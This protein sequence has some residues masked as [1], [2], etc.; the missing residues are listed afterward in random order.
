MGPS[1]SQ[2]R[3]LLL[4]PKVSFESHVDIVVTF[5][6]NWKILNW[7]K[8]YKTRT[9]RRGHASV[10]VSR[11]WRLTNE[12]IIIFLYKQGK[13]KIERSEVMAKS[14][15]WVPFINLLQEWVCF[16]II[17]QGGTKRLP[18]GRVP[19]E[20]DTWRDVKSWQGTMGQG[21]KWW[22]VRHDH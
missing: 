2:V 14:P 3:Q 16:I 19:Q 21:W 10:T 7:K 1:S 13:L 20:D 8:N 9:T 18:Q 17:Y 4:R 22:S 6:S 15:N 5:P 12:G 11:M